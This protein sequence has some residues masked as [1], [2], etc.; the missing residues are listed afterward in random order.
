MCCEVKDNFAVQ[1]SFSSM[2][3]LP[4]NFRRTNHSKN[5]VW[6]ENTR[7]YVFGDDRVSIQILPKNCI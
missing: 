5:N 1:I 4:R 3:P 6:D 2:S 7:L